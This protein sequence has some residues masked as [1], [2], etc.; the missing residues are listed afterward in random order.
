MI[1]ILRVQIAQF[2]WKQVLWNVSFLQVNQKTWLLE[3]VFISYIFNGLTSNIQSVQQLKC[4]FASSE[5]Q[6]IDFTFSL[7]RKD[8]LKYPF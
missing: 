6:I 1:K 8:N 4:D 7:L 2:K 5:V 3:K